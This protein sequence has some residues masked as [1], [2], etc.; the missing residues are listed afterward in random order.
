MA[1]T[2][3]H[4]LW[5]GLYRLQIVWV[6]QHRS[7]MVRYSFQEQVYMVFVYGQTGG[8]G[9]KSEW[10]YRATC[11]D[12]QYHPH[13]TTF[14]TIYRRLCEHGSFDT[15]ERAVRPH[16]V[17]KPVVE[18]HS[19]LDHRTYTP[20][21]FTCGVIYKTLCTVSLFLM[22]RPFNSVSTQPVILFGHSPEHSN[23]WGIPRC[24]VCTHFIASHGGHFEH[25]LWHGWDSMYSVPGLFISCCSP[26]P[27]TEETTNY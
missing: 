5:C 13:H 24:E 20:W 12:R 21:I 23:E 18:E 19:L 11:P 10:M 3:S 4:N 27:S 14:G 17:R 22:F 1:L 7:I 2:T 25:L 6:K 15:V 8:N 9:R 26:V 16:T